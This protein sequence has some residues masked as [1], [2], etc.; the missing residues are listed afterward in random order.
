MLSTW[1]H[2]MVS[3]EEG[4]KQMQA[5]GTALD[6]V[7]EGTAL[8][9]SDATGTSVGLG[10]RPDRTGRLHS[11]PVSWGLKVMRAASASLKT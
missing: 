9:E 5:G 11:M 8:V 1:Y 10:G 3:N 7:V 6:A 2:G 4:W